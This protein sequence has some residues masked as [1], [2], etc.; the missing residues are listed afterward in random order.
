MDYIN[1]IGHLPLYLYHFMVWTGQGFINQPWPPYERIF[2]GVVVSS[3]SFVVLLIPK[4]K[5]ELRLRRMERRL[6]KKHSGKVS[7]DH[8]AASAASAGIGGMFH[9]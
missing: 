7:S 2:Q 8:Q 5:A 9:H 3:I 1:V 6:H 4:S